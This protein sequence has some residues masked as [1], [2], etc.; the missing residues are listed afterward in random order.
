MLLDP[1]SVGNGA[2]SSLG[3]ACNHK[4]VKGVCDFLH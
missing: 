3:L 1:F 2:E 4:H